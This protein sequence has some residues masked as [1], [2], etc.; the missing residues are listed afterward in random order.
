MVQASGVGGVPEPIFSMNGAQLVGTEKEDTANRATIAHAI[1]IVFAVLILTP[2]N[3]V[4][5][6]LF[7]TVKLHVWFSV[8]VLMFLISGFGL[9]FAVSGEYNRVSE[10][11]LISISS[12]SQHV[13]MLGP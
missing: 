2:I 4:L 8:F 10:V 12:I 5:V 1:L 6:G 7:K 13:H 9:G 3:V 11:C